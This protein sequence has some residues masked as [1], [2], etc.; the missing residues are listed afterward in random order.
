M[1][2]HCFIIN[3]KE[4]GV[5]LDISHFILFKKHLVMLWSSSRTLEIY[6]LC[7]YILIFFLNVLFE[8]AMYAGRYFWLTGKAF[9]D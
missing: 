1:Q 7:M 3:Q 8:M 4:I 2:A 5:G 6:K 9:K